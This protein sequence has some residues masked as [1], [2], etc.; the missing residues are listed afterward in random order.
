[1]LV[2]TESSTNPLADEAVAMVMCTD[3]TK[4]RGA[5]IQRPFVV[6]LTGGIASG[7]STAGHYFSQQGICVVDAD[8]ISRDLVTPN[9]P[10]LTQIQTKLGPQA[11][12]N[13]GNLNRRWL[14]EQIMTQPEIKH[15]LEALMHPAI[16]KEMHEQLT[17]CQSPYAIAMIPLLAETGVPA[18][19]DC[20]LVVDCSPEQQLRRL[21][22]RDEMNE[23]Q[24]RDMLSLQASREERLKLAHGVID[25]TG[26]ESQMTAQLHNWHQRLLA[27]AAS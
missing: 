9:S 8:Q 23:Q 5:D 19:V 14:R 22:Q 12:L 3:G 26:N 16:R 7:K 21:M 24:A 6:A 4:Q 2:R 27:L 11:L 25:N 1:M 17:H 10:M 15:W 20:V 13:D 18:F